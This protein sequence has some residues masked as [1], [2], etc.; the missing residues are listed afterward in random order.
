MRAQLVSEMEPVL[1][2]Q[3]FREKGLVGLQQVMNGM[4]IVIRMV[5]K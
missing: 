3:R 5:S 2:K 4:G 1:Q